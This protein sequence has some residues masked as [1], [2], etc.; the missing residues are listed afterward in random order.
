MNVVNRLNAEELEKV[1]EM[2]K[3]KDEGKDD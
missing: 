2:L 1:A 3:S